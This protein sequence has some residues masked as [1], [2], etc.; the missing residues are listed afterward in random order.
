MKFN[1][2]CT[3]YWMPLKRVV[4]FFTWFLAWC[5]S[6]WWCNPLKTATFPTERNNIRIYY[7]FPHSL[8]HNCSQFWMEMF[9][10]FQI[11]LYEFRRFNDFDICKWLKFLISI[12]ARMSSLLDVSF[13][14]STPFS[15]IHHD[16]IVENIAKF[17]RTH[18]NVIRTPFASDWRMERHVDIIKHRFWCSDSL[19]SQLCLSFDFILFKF[20]CEFLWCH[21]EN[22][23]QSFV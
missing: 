22:I 7:S 10:T 13:H 1:S 19:K 18:F 9:S 4:N 5:K 20:D 12:F 16:W 2:Y 6:V 17:L 3:L 21:A 14:F 23:F 11:I 8:L 15:P